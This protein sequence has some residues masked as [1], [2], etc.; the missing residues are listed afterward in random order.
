MTHPITTAMT[1]AGLTPER[2]EELRESLAKSARGEAPGRF[3]R[4]TQA[5]GGEPVH[6]RKDMV[7]VVGRFNGKTTIVLENEDVAYEVKESPE[8]VLRLIGEE[9]SLTNQN[10]YGTLSAQRRQHAK[11]NREN[12]QKV[13]PGSRQGQPPVRPVERD[14]TPVL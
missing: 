8:Q 3:A 10:Q 2:L 11:E 6:V 5:I 14:E 9:G 12:R 13:P 7:A 4:L 1:L